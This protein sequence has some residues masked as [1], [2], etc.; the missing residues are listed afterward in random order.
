MTATTHLDEIIIRPA[1]AADADALRRLAAL[2]SA[3][4]PE[5][6]L[7]VAVA[8]G[9]LRAVLAVGSGRH[10]ADPFHPSRELLE[11]LAARARAM[12]AGTRRE[13][14]AGR[15]MLRGRLTRGALA[16]RPGH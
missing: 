14:M 3:R 5:G 16:P 12:R 8:G 13:R 11:L 10:V 6:D 9:E 15:L 2:D 1:R 7:L 4:I